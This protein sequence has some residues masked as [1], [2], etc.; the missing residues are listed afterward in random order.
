M[1][2]I[3]IEESRVYQLSR[4]DSQSGRIRGELHGTS[5]VPVAQ[6]RKLS[7]IFRSLRIPS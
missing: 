5:F 6:S 3:T 7:R 2:F 4:A 1:V